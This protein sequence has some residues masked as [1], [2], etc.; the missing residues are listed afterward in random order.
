MIGSISL[1][2]LMTA[3]GLE[4]FGRQ[5]LKQDNLTVALL[6]LYLAFWSYVLG[7]GTAFLGLVW[8]LVSRRRARLMRR[9]MSRYPA[10][11]RRRHLSRTLVDLEEPSW[12]SR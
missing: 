12:P 1:L 3:A 11:S 10:E 2:L 6:A 8:S 5:E 4:L 7:L 9:T